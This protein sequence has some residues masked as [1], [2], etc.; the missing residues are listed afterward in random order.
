MKKA[1]IT[2]LFFVGILQ[3]IMAQTANDWYKKGNDF[4]EKK[5]FKSAISSYTKALE[6]NPQNE[7]FFYKRGRCY[8]ELNKTQQAFED[9]TLG[10]KIN[11]FS[12][13]IYL[14][15]GLIFL[16][17]K[18]YD[19]ANTDLTMAINYAK[20][21]SIRSHALTARGALRQGKHDMQGAYED[22]TKAL[23]HDSLNLMTLNN[24]ATV[25]DD[26]N[27]KEEAINTLNKIIKMDSTFFGAYLNMAFQLT[28]AGKYKEAGPYF[29][30]AISIAPKEPYNYNNRGYNKFKQGDIE[31]ALKDINYSLKLDPTNSWAYKN[32][33]EIY[34]SQ[35]KP[36]KAC[37]ELEKANELG[38]SLKY[39]DAVNELIK[40]HCQTV[41]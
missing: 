11:A 32:R 5:D 6:L 20:V 21:D 22:Y 24:L 40:K 23:I 13:K 7:D 4:Y 1:L 38:F 17:A 3:S 27:K 26:L 2:I 30:K 12:S 41:K 16:N 19:E 25:L 34:I 18:M 39:G 31:G 9:F 8:F 36:D 28:Q 35:N 33:A 29:D 14:Y 10:I 37:K 15:R